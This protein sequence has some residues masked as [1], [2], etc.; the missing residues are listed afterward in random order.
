MVHVLE[1]M[2]GMR[3]SLW[4]IRF[5]ISAFKAPAIAN[6]LFTPRERLLFSKLLIALRIWSAFLFHG[7]SKDQSLSSGCVAIW[8]RWS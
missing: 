4:S 8:A 3:R 6:R 1:G 5:V 7:L 2:L